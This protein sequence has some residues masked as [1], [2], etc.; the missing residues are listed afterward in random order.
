[1][2][3]KI[4]LISLFIVIFNYSVIAQE[5]EHQ[6]VS[7]F[8]T[9]TITLTPIISNSISVQNI[10]TGELILLNTNCGLSLDINNSISFSVNLPLKSILPLAENIKS[11]FL[12]GD[13]S[14]DA[15]YS[16]KVSDLRLSSGISL[17]LPTGVY[18]S[19]EAE[20]KGAYSGSGYIAPSISFGL[21]KYSDP[22]VMGLNLSYSCGL[23]RK[24]RF[25]TSWRPCD[26]T[27][28]LRY[29]EILNH[30]TGYSISLNSSFDAAPVEN[31]QFM[32][33]DSRFSMSANIT[34]FLSSGDFTIRTGAS[35]SLSSIQTDTISIDSS[36]QFTLYKKENK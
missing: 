22:V 34:V 27:A 9:D 21:N 19:Y 24:E 8:A 36:Y 1:M 17:S 32:F 11:T 18:E 5:S 33:S 35:K 14:G 29:T 13:V 10:Q 23:P 20:V 16:W 30:E 7:V 26:I 28:S 3:N 25:G 31:G 15:S 2:K 12:L 6:R 4:L